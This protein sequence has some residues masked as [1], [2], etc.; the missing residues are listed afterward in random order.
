[1]SIGNLEGTSVPLTGDPLIDGLTSS[2]KWQLD[3]TRTIDWSISNGFNGEYW[4]TP[5]A[6]IALIDGLFADTAGFIDVDFRYR[7][8]F[9]DPND[10]IVQGSD[11]N[12]AWDAANLFFSDP[13]QWALVFYP[14]PGLVPRGDTFFNGN[15]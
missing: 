12:F 11:I 3:S 14:V 8:Y 6:A 4:I 13:S 9:V 5:S 2:Y 10:A 1:M 15:S 7:G